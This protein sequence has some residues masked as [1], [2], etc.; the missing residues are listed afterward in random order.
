MTVNSYDEWFPLKEVILGS[1][2]NYTSHERELS[3]DLFFHDSVNAL[4]GRI[5]GCPAR[6]TQVHGRSKQYACRDQS[7][8][9]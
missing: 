5:H 8:L 3:F 2:T 7:D 4:S 1:A 6:A 9:R